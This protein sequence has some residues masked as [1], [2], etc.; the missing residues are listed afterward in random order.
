M[1]GERDSSEVY[2]VKTLTLFILLNENVLVF[3]G[4]PRGRHEW[5]TSAR[6]PAVDRL[7]QGA[8]NVGSVGA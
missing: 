2:G 8:G 4:R 6:M 7:A 1:I 3:V 5:K